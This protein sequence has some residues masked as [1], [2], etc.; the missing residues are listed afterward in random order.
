MDTPDDVELETLEG[1]LLQQEKY[2]RNRIEHVEQKRLSEK[3]L[4]FGTEQILDYKGH[5]GHPVF[6]LVMNT[7]KK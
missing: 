4:L 7:D 1:Q 3:P 5:S 6:G 2:R